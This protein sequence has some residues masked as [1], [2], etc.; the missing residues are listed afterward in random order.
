MK[1]ERGRISSTSFP[2]GVEDGGSML[3]YRV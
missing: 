3:E 2:A 1:I